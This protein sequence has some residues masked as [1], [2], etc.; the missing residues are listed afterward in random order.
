M[1]FLS[2][3]RGGIRGWR[4]AASS[5]SSPRGDWASRVTT[6]LMCTLIVFMI[7]PEDFNY[8]DI[9]S[10][11][12]SGDALSRLVW[13]AL[14]CGSAAVVLR[15]AVPALR[16][17]RHFNAFFLAFLLLAC[18]SVAWSVEPEFT[19]RRVIR[20]VTISL[21]ALAFV[22]TRHRRIQDVL[23]PM[24]TVMLVGSI[25]LVLL[26]PQWGIERSSAAELIGA[27]RGLATQKNGLGSL[28][29]I[30]TLLWMHAWLA[31]EARWQVVAAGLAVSLLCLFCSR[32]SSALLATA[33]TAP[34]MAALARPPGVL[35][36]YM[37][38]LVGVFAVGLLVY[39]LAVLRVV[40]GSETLLYPLESLTGKDPTFSGRTA[41][42]DIVSEHIHYSPILGGGYGAY[43]T[44]P[45]PGTPSY[46]QVTRLF[47]YPTEAHNGYLDIINDL[48]SVGGACLFGYL[49]TYLRQSLTILAAARAQGA[50]Y[51]GLFFEQLIANLTESRWLNVLCIE[52]VIMTLATAAMARTLL[53]IHLQRQSKRY[54]HRSSLVRGRASSG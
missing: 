9:N 36:R 6:L 18:A 39:S 47:F 22:L 32:S 40:P 46:E 50:L 19:A 42:W 52:F 12:E 54:E 28:A 29:A 51:L 15:F 13:L 8:A 16:V 3:V 27:W 17:L 33:F 37:P 35:R 4:G 43:W 49:L 24:V 44:G 21:T 26:A 10:L 31:R 34:F 2:G 30:G 23:R 25:A 5:R 11:P 48:G 38:Y 1:M 41:I 20:L 53:E 7:V 14:L 45:V